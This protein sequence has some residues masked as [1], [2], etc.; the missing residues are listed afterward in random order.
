MRD[1]IHERPH[2][3]KLEFYQI[4][5]HK[6]A[7]PTADLNRILNNKLSFIALIQGP[8]FRSGKIQGLNRSRGNVIHAEGKGKQR[9]CIYIS[10]DWIVQ[11]LYHLCTRDLCVARVKAKKCGN[12]F[13]ILIS[14]VYF[15][16]DS[17]ENPPT[18]EF[19]NLINYS[20]S[21][22]IPILSSI[23]A[24]AHHHAWGSKDINDRVRSY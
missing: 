4:N 18:E 22:A 16:Y 7:T 17:I 20:K 10:K 5:L 9:A 23:D 6:S 3:K 15:P 13:E 8:S 2:N 24:N 1:I 19:I 12:D 14:S 21:N 11:P